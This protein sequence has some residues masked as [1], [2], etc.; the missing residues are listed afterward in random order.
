MNSWDKWT[1]WQR[2]LFAVAMLAFGTLLVV[3]MRVM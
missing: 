2:V 3:L 1:Q